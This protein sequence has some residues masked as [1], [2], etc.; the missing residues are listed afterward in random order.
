MNGHRLQ[1]IPPR[2]QQGSET[3]E[4]AI[5]STLLF[6]IL[7][8][9]IEFSVALYDKAILTNASRE[10]AGKRYF[11]SPSLGILQQRMLPSSRKFATTL[12]IIW[13]RLVAQQILRL[14]FPDLI[15]ACHLEVR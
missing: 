1:G 12:M 10:E 3:V 11:S 8:G 2:K 9:I 6:I 14:I 15:P 13:S 4:F 5:S 7:F